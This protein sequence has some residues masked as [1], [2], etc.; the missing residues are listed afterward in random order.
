V[1]RAHHPLGG[2]AEQAQAEAEVHRA[3]QTYTAMDVPSRSTEEL[4]MRRGFEQTLQ[5]QARA[6]EQERRQLQARIA[7][8]EATRAATQVASG[9][10]GAFSFRPTAGTQPIQICV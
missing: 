6:F 5:E 2:V 4:Q 10:D 8:V 7:S 1:A 3:K 9:A